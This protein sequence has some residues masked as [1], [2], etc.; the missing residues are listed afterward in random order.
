MPYTLIEN[1]HKCTN[2]FGEPLYVR[3]S[4]LLNQFLI[5]SSFREPTDPERI[6]LEGKAPVMGIYC[7]LYIT[8][9]V[10]IGDEV[11]IHRSNDSSVELNHREAENPR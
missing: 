6:S 4:P 2:N 1:V 9:R 7:G 8:G 5:F 3:D 11:F 10:K